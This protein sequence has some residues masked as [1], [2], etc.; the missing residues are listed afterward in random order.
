MNQFQ[1]DEEHLDRLRPKLCKLICDD[2][3]FKQYVWVLL[4][5]AKEPKEGYDHLV[6]SCG[7]EKE[8]AM[9][10]IEDV[11]EKHRE[12]GSGGIQ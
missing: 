5:G 2:P 12:E 7:I 1:K 11:V 8:P 3:Y 4:L 10:F 9:N 6:L